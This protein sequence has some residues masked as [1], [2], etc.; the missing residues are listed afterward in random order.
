M[1]F[2]SMAR[3]L[4]PAERARQG[5]THPAGVGAGRPGCWGPLALALLA[6][7]W[8]A[9]R[10]PLKGATIRRARATA[11]PQ[12]IC[13]SEFQPLQCGPAGGEISA[14]EGRA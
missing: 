3:R 13:P 9:G 10:G 8:R 6:A 14:R 7:S 5:H 1:I 2:T 12:R 11:R 4:R